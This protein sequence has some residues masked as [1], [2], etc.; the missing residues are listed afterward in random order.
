EWADSPD[1]A[2]ARAHEVAKKAA[3]LDPSYPW[4]KVA[5]GNTFLWTGKLDQAIA[6]YR[7]ALDLDPNFADA[8]MTLGWTL[9]FDGRAEE[10]IEL[11]ERGLL[12]DPNYTP[13]RLHWLAQCLFQ[14]GR[15]ED[16]AAK[17]QLRLARQPHSDVSHALLAATYGHLGDKAAAKR[18]WAELLR[19]NPNFSV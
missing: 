12:L 5:L 17:L 13:M 1:E 2:L 15:Y 3:E 16:A 4:A 19:V 18:Q 7:S 14:L 6:L 10:A 8:Y 11:I 9:H